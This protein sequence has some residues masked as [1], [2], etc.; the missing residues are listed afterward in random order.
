M[1]VF[2]VE[3]PGVDAPAS[4]DGGTPWPFDWARDTVVGAAVATSPPTMRV[5]HMHRMFILASN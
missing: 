5:A 3:P 1:L 4:V 2:G